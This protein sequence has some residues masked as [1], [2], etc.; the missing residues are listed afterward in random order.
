M[1]Q[2]SSNSEGNFKL[3]ILYLDKCKNKHILKTR[4]VS[5]VQHWKETFIL[6]ILINVPQQENL[7]Q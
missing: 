1:K 2:L 3:R 5:N 6:K 7:I 4:D